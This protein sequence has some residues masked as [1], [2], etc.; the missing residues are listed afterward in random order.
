[1]KRIRKCKQLM[2]PEEVVGQE[3]SLVG[4]LASTQK[5]ANVE[6]NCPRRHH[7]N[8]SKGVWIR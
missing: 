1:M 3:M 4:R 5:K 8:Q 7:T 6:V 2:K